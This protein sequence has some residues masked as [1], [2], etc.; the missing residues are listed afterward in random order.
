M[1]AHTEEPFVVSSSPGMG[2]VPF[3]QPVGDNPGKMIHQGWAAT[4]LARP[5]PEQSMTLW[6][7]MVGIVHSWS[8]WRES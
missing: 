2:N 3:A 8:A 7:P 5:V 1:D 4:V 6:A